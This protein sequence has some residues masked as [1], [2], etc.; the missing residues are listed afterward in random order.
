LEAQPGDLREIVPIKEI[1]SVQKKAKKTELAKRATVGLGGDVKISTGHPGG[2]RKTVI[3]KI[4]ERR[5][6]KMGGQ[7][8]TPEPGV[9]DLCG[10]QLGGGMIEKNKNLIKKHLNKPKTMSSS[11]KG[12]IK[13]VKGENLSVLNE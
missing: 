11:H 5:P 2:R 4:A 13:K 9:E 10:T 1:V 3:G 7:I 12:K 6:S 8:L